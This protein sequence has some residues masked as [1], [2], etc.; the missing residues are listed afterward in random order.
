MFETFEIRKK[1]ICAQKH[2][3]ANVDFAS[4]VFYLFE[5]CTASRSRTYLSSQVERWISTQKPQSDDEC[6]S[7]SFSG[8]AA[9]HSLGERDHRSLF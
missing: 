3:P 6:E 5:N 4:F 7:H 9:K 1:C 2:T 8:Q